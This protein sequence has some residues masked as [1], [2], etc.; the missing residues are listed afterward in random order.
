MIVHNPFGRWRRPLSALL[1]FAATLVLGLAGAP[2][3]GPV[4][5]FGWGGLGLLL[6]GCAGMLAWHAARMASTP[7][8]PSGQAG[9]ALPAAILALAV[10]GIGAAALIVP[11]ALAILVARRD[12]DA[13]IAALAVHGGALALLVT[14]SASPL[15][16]AFA[17]AMIPGI[18][19]LSLRG[20]ALG[21][22]NDNPSME[23]L[24]DIWPLHANATYANQRA[25]NSESGSWGVA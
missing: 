10:P 15:L 25:G 5:L 17:C 1:T 21:Y 24:E 3:P 22:A 16:G 9:A 6:A 12:S 20:A 14:G 13:R 7:A 23:R 19:W 11:C 18:A 8:G 2:L 4:A